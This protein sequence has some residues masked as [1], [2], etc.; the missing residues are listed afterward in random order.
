MDDDD[1]KS[2]GLVPGI[3]EF[4][5]KLYK[6]LMDTTGDIVCWSDS[7]TSFL[8]KDISEFTKNLLP[9]NFKHGNFASFVRQL[10]KY[11]FHK[12]KSDDSRKIGT[13][14]WE[15]SHSKFIKDQPQLLSQIKR[16]VPA[17]VEK[18]VSS[19]EIFDPNS[20]SKNNN[21]EISALKS[22][23]G[24]LENVQREM[25]SHLKSLTLQYQQVFD[26]MTGFRHTVSTQEQ[27]IRGLIEF[28]PNDK[29]SCN[30]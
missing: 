22:K 14:P 12:V 13:Q 3:P 30:F 18:R 29:K 9:G 7:G 19:P 6:M 16:K 15:F 27:V 4:I 5:V 11:D 8:I 25:S 10:N 24:F 26:Q 1:D 2:F 17:K 21:L 20:P 23:I 28:V